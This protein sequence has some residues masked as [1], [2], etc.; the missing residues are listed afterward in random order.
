M[1]IPSLSNSPCSPTWV[2]PGHLPDEPADLRG[3]GWSALSVPTTLPSPVQLEAF[4]VP[5]DDG[6]RFH[7]GERV[8]PAR[9]DS[10]QQHPE[11]AVALLQ[12]RTFDGPPQDRDL[13]PKCEIL[14]GQLS[15]GRQN[16]NQGSEQR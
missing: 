12:M 8:S 11:E 9:P 10:G 2:G 7:D 16:G 5:S 13:L 4:A 14:K 15:V 3:N 1:L 6:L